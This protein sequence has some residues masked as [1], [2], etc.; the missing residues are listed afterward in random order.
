MKISHLNYHFLASND[1]YFQIYLFLVFHRCSHNFHVKFQ[2]FSS[3]FDSFSNIIYGATWNGTLLVTTE[4]C[5]I[6]IIYFRFGLRKQV[7]QA[8]FFELF[9]PM[10]RLLYRVSY[11]QATSSYHPCGCLLWFIKVCNFSLFPKCCFCIKLILDHF[12]YLLIV[13]RYGT[14]LNLLYFA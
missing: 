7:K 9:N 3:W 5:H 1:F 6:L 2:V 13:S 4:G 12:G 11:H 8:P 10:V 14:C